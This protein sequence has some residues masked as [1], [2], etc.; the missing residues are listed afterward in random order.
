MSS[1]VDMKRQ[2][3][4]HVAG[5]GSLHGMDIQWVMACCLQSLQEMVGQRFPSAM[6]HHAIFLQNCSV[7]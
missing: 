1:H 4:L 3:I 7:S 2:W 5:A 6:A